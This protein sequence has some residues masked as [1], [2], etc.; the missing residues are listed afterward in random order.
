VTNGIP[1][2]CSL[3]LPVHTVNHHGKSRPNAEDS[4]I[5]TALDCTDNEYNPA[6]KT[7][8]IPLGKHRPRCAQQGVRF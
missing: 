6:L 8:S 1:L 3:L 7:S 4:T 2:E 5:A